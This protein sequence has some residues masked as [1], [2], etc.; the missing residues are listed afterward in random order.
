[1]IGEY[2]NTTWKDDDASN[3]HIPR[4]R[5]GLGWNNTG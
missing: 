1:M 3:L 2:L 5:G 4:A